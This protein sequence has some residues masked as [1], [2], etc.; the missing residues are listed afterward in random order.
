M[1]FGS[2][3]DLDEYNRTNEN[4]IYCKAQLSRMGLKPK[5][6]AKP[7][8]HKVCYDGRWKAYDFYT[9]DSVTEKRKVKRVITDLEV[10]PENLCAA[11][12][13]INKSAKLSR[14]TAQSKY[15]IG[16]HGQAKRAKT[17][18]IELYRLKDKTIRKFIDAGILELAGYNQQITTRTSYLLLYRYKTYSFHVPCDVKP[19]GVAFC[20]EINDLISS[21]VT[22]DKLIKYSDAV[23]LL[24]K[25][26]ETES[27]SAGEESDKVSGIA[28]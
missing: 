17:R 10:T 16:D 14:D 6:D 18:K 27:G 3:K 4:P 23:R 12:Y 15:C 13:I 2:W 22:R 19:E 24:E 9:L 25:Y 5:A 28:S 20:G 8:A 1:N 7:T 21:Q 26:C 11:L